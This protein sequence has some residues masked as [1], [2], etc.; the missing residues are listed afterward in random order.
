MAARNITLQ[1][2]MVAIALKS[3]VA[4]E[5]APETRNMCVGQPDKD[6]HE[7]M[8]IVA[9]KSCTAC[10]EIT[11]YAALVKG[12]KQ[13]SS[14][15]I[16]TQEDVADA[17]E[18]YASEYKGV[19][20]LVAHPSAQFLAET[21]PGDT[22]HYLTPADTASENRYKVMVKLVQ[23]HPELTFAS[24]HTPSSAT[25][26][27]MLRVRDGVLVMEKR[28]RSQALK[29]TPSVGGE[30][31]DVMYAQLEGMLPMFVTDYDADAY[32]DKYGLA[33]AE[34]VANADTVTA[35]GTEP[36]KATAPAMFTDEELTAALAE[37]AATHATT[38]A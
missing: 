7:A 16:I 20:N 6:A 11:D 22:L 23:S 4:V 18:E 28:T 13:G 29:P 2:G 33:L 32:E 24:L 35:A 9:P 8:L 21:G 14:Y 12:V 17:K 3:E 37:F 25:A 1:L 38:A 15:A 31:N 19:L 30:V 36:T 10:G 27:F 26:L 5:K 34:M